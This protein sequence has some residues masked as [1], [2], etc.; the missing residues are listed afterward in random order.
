MVGIGSTGKM[1]IDRLI[2]HA[3]VN[4]APVQ[5]LRFAVFDQA[6][7]KAALEIPVLH[8]VVDTSLPAHI[9]KRI[10]VRNVDRSQQ[11]ASFADILA[12]PDRLY[13]MDATQFE[14]F[15]AGVYT[16]LGYT[17]FATKQSHDGGVDLMLENVIDGMPHRYI[18]QCKHTMK[19][20][21]RIG[22]AAVRELMGSL[23]DWAATAAIVVTNTLFSREALAY[24][25]RRA[26]N[27]FCVDKNSFLD[28]L[29]KAVLA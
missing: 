1:V 12:R 13:R 27:C 4:G 3:A 10:A 26:R 22:V 20:S 16:Q 9:A 15:V 21:R 11:Y 8:A 14:E 23:L 6:S 7:G 25:Q 2:E 5:Q 18:V 24:M 29:R 17:V 28:L 19:K